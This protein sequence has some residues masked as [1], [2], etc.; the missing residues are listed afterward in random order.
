MAQPA[1]QTQITVATVDRTPF[2]FNTDNGVRTGFSIE[3]M[4]AIAT[5]NDYSV[6]Y[7]VYDSYKTMLNAV[8]TNHADMAIANISVNRE[9]EK[10]FDFSHPIFT[11]S[12]GILMKTQTPGLQATLLYFGKR[13]FLPFSLLL[14]VVWGFAISIWFFERRTHPYFNK[15]LRQAIFPAFW[16]AL[17]STVN[18]GGWDDEVPHS[19]Q[20]R[21]LGILMLLTSLVGLT[22]FIGFI[23]AEQ[24][25][26][27]LDAEVNSIHDL[28]GKSVGAM[29]DSANSAFLRTINIPH[30]T[31]SDLTGLYEAFEKGTIEAIVYDTPMLQYYLSSGGDGTLMPF[32]YHPHPYAILCPDDSPYLESINTGLLSVKED[33]TFSTL[34]DKYF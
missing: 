30:T 20:G 31:F 11:N 15:P 28:N 25:V 2:S 34:V 7:D 21:L 17:R 1:K 33:G 14:V 24:T 22:F 8:K 29:K 16:W 23:T 32:N 5:Q 26:S 19:W 12:T 3:L 27:R 9:R 4:D 13:L 10:M 18:N 6:K